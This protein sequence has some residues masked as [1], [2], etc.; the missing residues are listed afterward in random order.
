MLVDGERVQVALVDAHHRGPEGEGPCQLVLV[1]HLY[2]DVEPEP[3]RQPRQIA[4][5]VVVEGGHDQQDR[6]GT[7]DPGVAHVG[8]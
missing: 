5:L 6:V 4:Q 3:V 2:Q 7:H 1:V 8:G